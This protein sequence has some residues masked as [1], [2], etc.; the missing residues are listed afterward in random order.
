MNRKTPRGLL[1]SFLSACVFACAASVAAAQT[2]GTSGNS[3]PVAMKLPK[4]Y[5]PAPFPDKRA[6]QVLL[7]PKRPAGMYVVYPKAGETTEAFN[8]FLKKMVAEMFF[9]DSKAP[10][11]WTESALPSHKGVDNE[12]GTLFY[13]S[14]DKLEIQLA[15]YN[16]TVGET[17]VSYGYYAMRHKG[18]KSKDDGVFLDG[19]GGGVK[20]FEKFCQSIRPSK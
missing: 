1:L 10:V 18:E 2:D 3:K 11:T 13:A 17:K 14:D 15:A 19:S 5:M 16:R 8:E 6:G 20:D 7:D 9:H 4:N 12:S